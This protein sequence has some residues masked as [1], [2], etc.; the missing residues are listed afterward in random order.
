M[1]ASSLLHDLTSFPPTPRDQ[2]ECVVPMLLPLPARADKYPPPQH[3]A[4]S[5]RF[6]NWLFA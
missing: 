6:K 2:A 4:Q 3:C 5:Q 1:D